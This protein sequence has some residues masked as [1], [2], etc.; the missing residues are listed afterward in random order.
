M[1]D[2][3]QDAS[4]NDPVAS[5]ASKEVTSEVTHAESLSMRSI[6]RLAPHSVQLAKEHA[7]LAKSAWCGLVVAVAVVLCSL[8]AFPPVPVNYRITTQVVATPLR[9]EQ[10][11]KQLKSDE[12]VG[13]KARLVSVQTLDAHTVNSKRRNS[14]HLTLVEVNS[15]WPSR[16][17]GTELMQW[18]DEVSKVDAADLKQS[19]LTSAIRMAHW[20]VQAAE[21]YLTQ[22]RERK[23][24][25]A[26][27]DADKSILN[28]VAKTDKPAGSPMRLASMSSKSADDSLASSATGD[29][30]DA[31]TEARL[32]KALEAAKQAEKL[33]TSQAQSQI[34]Q[35]AGQ[36][37][38]SGA[39]KV[40]ALPGRVPNY[41]IYSVIVLAFCGGAIGG[42]I[43]HSSQ[44]GGV[45][46]PT[47]VA[48]A[49][50]VLGLPI[51]GAVRLKGIEPKNTSHSLLSNLTSGQ[52]WIVQKLQLTAE[53]VVLFW[54]MTLVIRICL[55][56]LWR[57][58]L[59]D[60][61]LAALGRLFLGLP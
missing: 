24:L 20:E 5:A 40:R 2:V 47:D 14:E 1:S 38:I 59:W 32:I 54:C 57:T 7:F 11:R 41:M 25:M 61:P 18:L 21:G 34:A 23:Q 43:H 49:M 51:L 48:R 26:A 9:L 37:S 10:I 3:V 52:R 28:S 16:T 31:E 50:S 42:W 30:D 29:S 56:P 58:M 19:D 60:S 13:T 33:A 39:P 6:T 36:L 53:V 22:F 12:A 17:T 4:P 35:V 45:F 44:S 55:D 15:V 46:Y 27:N 8:N